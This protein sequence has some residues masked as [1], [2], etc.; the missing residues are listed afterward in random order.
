MGESVLLRSFAAGELAPGLYARADLAKYATG[1]RRCRNFIVRRHGGVSNRAGTKFIAATKNSASAR[2]LLRPFIFAAADQSFVV[3]CGDNYFRFFRNG[4]RVTTSGVAA[5]NGATPYVPGDLVSQGGVH[6]YCIANTTGNAPPNVLFWYPLTMLSGTVGIYEI[7]TPYSS[8]IFQSPSTAGWSQQGFVVSITHKNHAP[9]ELTYS[10]ATRWVLTTVTTGPSQAK[11]TGLSAT[12]GSVGAKTFRYVVTAAKADT[13][14][15]SGASIAFDLAAAGDPTDLAPHVLTWVAPAGAPPEYYIYSDGGFSNGTLGYLGTATGQ[16]TFHDVGQVPDFNVTPPIARVL[17]NSA[18]NYPGVSTVHQQRRWYASTHNAPDLAHASRTGFRANFDITSPLQDDDAIQF[19]MAG[20]QLQVIKHLIGLKVGLVVFTE[21]G[22]WVIQGDQDGV[23]TPTAINLE[24]HSYCGADFTTPVLIG[25]IV[26]FV[27]ARG[28]IL[29]D[30]F[31]EERVQGLGGRDLALY[32]SHLTRGYTVVNMAYAQTPDSIVWI[33]RNDGTLLGLTYLNEEEV[34]AWHRH[35]TDGTFEDVCVIPESDGDA[36]Y[37]VVNRT[38]NG[39]TVRYVERMASRDFA[40][41][42]DAFLV[43]SGITQTNG[44][45]STAVTGLTHL[46]G[47]TVKAFVDGVVQGPF[48]VTAG[49]LVTLTTAGTKVHVGLPIT[50][51]LETLD[52]DVSGATIRAQRK[53]VGRLALLLEA[54]Y[55]G[56][57]IGPD[58]THLRPFEQHGLWENGD[59]PF[60]GQA[61]Q[62]MTANWNDNGRVFIQHTDPSPLTVLGIIPHVEVGG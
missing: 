16:V 49:G 26:V 48:V 6:Y 38:I 21:S 8:G 11:P 19:T 51:E 44:A 29:R 9:A 54:S 58:S 30:L 31:F 15:E 24:Q 17:F 25:N 40:N 33:V 18:N 12:A 55:R 20:N 45:P 22:E 53:R 62:A 46:A 39:G 2:S 13:Y 36:V 35:D 27:Q 59:T 50:A 56:F 34:V 32:S 23:I 5:Y 14:E 4:A 37:V 7:P 28:T 52:L 42:Q 3:E 61:D 57:S 60:T 41:V 43:D 10:S 1:L 47:E